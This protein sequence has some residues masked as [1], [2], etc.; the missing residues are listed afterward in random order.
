[1]TWRA[2][3]GMTKYPLSLLTPPAINEESA[4]ESSTMLAYSAAS[5][6]SSTMRPL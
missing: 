3:Q 5:P 6:F 2:L 4:V 1:M